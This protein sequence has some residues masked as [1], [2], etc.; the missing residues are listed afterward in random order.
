MA[1]VIVYVSGGNIQDV[2]SD[3]PEVQVM[4][5]DYDNER[6]PGSKDRSFLP[7]TYD[8]DYFERTIAGVEQ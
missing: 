6:E 8:P 4:V 7:A 1:R 5:V 3:S 2:I